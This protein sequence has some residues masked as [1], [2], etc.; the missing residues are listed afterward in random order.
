M[1][2]GISTDGIAGVISTDAY[3]V[4]FTSRRTGADAEGYGVMAERMVEVAASMPGFLGIESARDA[5]GVG[6][7]VS[8]GSSEAAIRDRQRHAEHVEAQRL[9]RERWYEAFELRICRVARARGFRATGN[10]P[11]TAAR[12][13]RA[14]VEAW[15]EAFN[16]ADVDALASMYA[17]DA[18]N[19]RVAESP[20]VGREAIRAMFLAGFASTKMVCIPDNL[21]ED[22]A[23][24]ILE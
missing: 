15:I 20:V 6:T 14:V 4:A 8:Y 11:P 5:D 3:A 7:T 1:T 12:S 13:P 19:H 2:S 21:L 16:C 10:A 17:V 9:G 18:T 22:R 24:A 23:W